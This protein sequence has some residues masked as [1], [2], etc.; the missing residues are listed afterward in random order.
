MLGPV[1][2]QAIAVIAVPLKCDALPAPAV[3]KG[4]SVVLGDEAALTVIE[5]SH[6]GSLSICAHRNG[7]RRERLG[8]EPRTGHTLALL[9]GL[10]SH[11]ELPGVLNCGTFGA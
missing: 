8:I 6:G 7:E 4:C 3:P 5:L 1:A 2:R 9:D 10:D 11:H